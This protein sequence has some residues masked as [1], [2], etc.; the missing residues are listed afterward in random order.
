MN[1]FSLEFRGSTIKYSAFRNTWSMNDTEQE[2]IKSISIDIFNDIQLE[3]TK[4]K[5]ELHAEDIRVK[6]E[7]QVRENAEKQA[8]IENFKVLVTPLISSGFTWDI[9]IAGRVN[10][11]KGG[12]SAYVD[13]YNTRSAKPYAYSDTGWKTRRVSTLA[14]A[15]KSA[16]GKI[17]ERVAELAEVTRQK[18]IR[19]TEFT[20]FKERLLPFG[21]YRNFKIRKVMAPATQQYGQ[22]LALEGDPTSDNTLVRN[23]RIQGQFT[24]EQVKKL[25]EVV[26][27]MN[28]AKD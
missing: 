14:R 5:A 2:I 21:Y 8:A 12:V 11:H 10:L 7:R 15:I 20:I 4:K 28:V 19:E 16:E 9:P 23:V 24:F 6:A 13:S 26:M 17:N 22:M 1:D 25:A 27:E 18:G 3:V